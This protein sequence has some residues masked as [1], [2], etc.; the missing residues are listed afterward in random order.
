M[1]FELL[2]FVAASLCDLL[3]SVNVKAEFPV[4]TIV[5][6]LNSLSLAARPEFRGLPPEQAADLTKG[7]RWIVKDA[8]LSCLIPCECILIHINVDQ[9]KGGSRI[10]YTRRVGRGRPKED[11]RAQRMKNLRSSTPLSL[12]MLNPKRP[13]GNSQRALFYCWSDMPCSGMP[14][15]R[16]IAR[17]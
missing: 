8:A 1:R 11:L 10:V 16:L 4:D 15:R 2:S 17:A 13:T 14:Q 7:L 5:C 6:H 9:Y 12:E 3:D